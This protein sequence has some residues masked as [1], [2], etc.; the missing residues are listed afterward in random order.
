MDKFFCPTCPM[1]AL[2]MLSTLFKTDVLPKS[3]APNNFKLRNLPKSNLWRSFPKITIGS[4]QKIGD[5][6]YDNL[7]LNHN[8]G[9]TPLSYCH[10]LMRKSPF[11]LIISRSQQIL[12][13]LS[14][15]CF[16]KF[17][18]DFCFFCFLRCRVF[19]FTRCFIGN[20][21]V[22]L[23]FIELSTCSQKYEIY[24]KKFGFHTDYQKYFIFFINQ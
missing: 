7:L 1:A 17:F 8:D 20:H 10:G 2:G 15:L 22:S 11:G 5:S 23:S 9:I 12:H 21:W 14:L 13:I 19:R 6:N 3:P 4:G 16:L 18:F 24:N